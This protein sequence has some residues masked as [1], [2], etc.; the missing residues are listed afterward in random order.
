[1]GGELNT[2]P[3]EKWQRTIEMVQEDGR[4]LVKKMLLRSFDRVWWYGGLGNLEIV[5]GDANCGK[6]WV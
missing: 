3:V 6:S 2:H 1:M 5:G 4:R